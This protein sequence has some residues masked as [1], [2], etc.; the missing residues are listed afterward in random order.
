MG[1]PSA[2]KGPSVAEKA[3][4]AEREAQL[5]SQRERATLETERL[6]QQRISTGRARRGGLIGRRSL[7]TTSELGVTEALG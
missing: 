3:A 7:I 6:R 4:Q 1:F 5:K 2:P